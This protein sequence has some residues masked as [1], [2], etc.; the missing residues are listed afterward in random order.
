MQVVGL[1]EIVKLIGN[2]KTMKVAAIMDTGAKNTSI[3]HAL[4][5]EL[6][7]GEPVGTTFVKNPS[8]K[9]RTKREVVAIKIKVDGKTFDVLANIQDRS[10][11]THPV[12][13]GRN[14]LHGNFVVDVSKT[15]DTPS[16]VSI[17]DDETKELLKNRLDYQ[18][19]FVKYK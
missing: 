1:T 11:M 12:I 19:Y 5:E 9:S 4:A 2:K 3:D 14:V 7:F 18:D 16:L 17:K 13:V 8:K 10:H 6:D 15:H